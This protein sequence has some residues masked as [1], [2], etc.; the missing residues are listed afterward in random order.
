M[1]VLQLLLLYPFYHIIYF[2]IMINSTHWLHDAC[3]VMQLEVLIVLTS[4]WCGAF[5][6]W[7]GDLK[8]VVMDV[9]DPHQHATAPSTSKQFAFDCITK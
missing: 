8:S 6:C 2:Y 7:R 5:K 1:E 4:V 9:R 3:V